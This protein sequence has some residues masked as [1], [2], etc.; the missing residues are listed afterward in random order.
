[1]AG[2]TIVSATLNIKLTSIWS[3]SSDVLVAILKHAF[4]SSSATGDATEGIWGEQA[5][6]SY[7]IFDDQT[8][9]WISFDVKNYLSNDLTNGYDWSCWSVHPKEGA[10]DDYFYRGITFSS[11]EGGDA[12]YL[13]VNVVPVPPSVLLMG[14]A[15]LG[16]LCL[17]RLT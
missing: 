16:L 7:N 11:S 3:D 12:P 2:Q 17:R 15:L 9:G 1:L 14:P 5:L 10:L 4:N 8:P 13:L 6:S